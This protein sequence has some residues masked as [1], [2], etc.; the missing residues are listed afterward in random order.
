M[1]SS[2]VSS[3]RAGARVREQQRV[4]ESCGFRGVIRL[5]ARDHGAKLFHRRMRADWRLIR[6]F[7]V[8]ERAYPLS[9]Y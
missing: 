1:L 6:V 2:C 5:C 4:D 3:V 7:Q 8:R 9:H